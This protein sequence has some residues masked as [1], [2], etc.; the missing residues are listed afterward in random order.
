MQDGL[1]CD[2][3]AE[4]YFLLSLWGSGRADVASRWMRRDPMH[5]H[6]S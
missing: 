2:I 4:V 1:L 5:V 3:C 6:G